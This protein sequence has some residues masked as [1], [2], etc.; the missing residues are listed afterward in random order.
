VGLLLLRAPLL[1]QEGR[2]TKAASSPRPR[3]HRPP[4]LPKTPLLSKRA[5]SLAPLA[6]RHR[7]F[8]FLHP[9]RLNFTGS[10]L[11]KKPCGQHAKFLQT[12]LWLRRQ[13]EAALLRPQADALQRERGVKETRD[14]RDAND[15]DGAVEAGE[16][17]L[18]ELPG[19]VKKVG[20]RSRR[21][22]VWRGSGG[23]GGGQAARD[24]RGGVDIFL[25][26]AHKHRLSSS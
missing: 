3:P 11:Q 26:K 13:L 22:R 18:E 1:L 15:V 17:V 5:N 9:L 20:G 10:T 24:A 6:W 2:G 7:P 14:G 12:A 21:R 23:G 19:E 25:A 8:A 16:D 4:S